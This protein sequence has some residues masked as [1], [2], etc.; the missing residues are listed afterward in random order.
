MSEI[1]TADQAYSAQVIIP[2]KVDLTLASDALDQISVPADI[3]GDNL[4]S[5]RPTYVSEVMQTR[6]AT[7][8][9]SDSAQSAARLMAELDIDL[10]P[11]EAPGVGTIIGIVRDRDIVTAVV[12]SGRVNTTAVMEFMTPVE[13]PCAPTDELRT[14]VGK[15]KRASCSSIVVLDSEHR[16]VGILAR[17]T[18]ECALQEEV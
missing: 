13:E 7:I 4:M 9:P 10:L 11:V 8:S 3:N 2:A 16:A 15:I 14:A 18:A 1:S 5:A 6:F 12:A 17:S